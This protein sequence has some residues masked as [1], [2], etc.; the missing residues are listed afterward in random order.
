VGELDCNAGVRFFWIAGLGRS[1]EGYVNFTEV[2][3]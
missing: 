2:L 1:G 3:S